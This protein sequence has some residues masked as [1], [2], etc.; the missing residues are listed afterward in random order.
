MITGTGA[1][2]GVKTASFTIGKAANP[3][4]IKTVGKTTCRQ[5]SLESAKKITIKVLRKQGKVTY[6]LSKAAK[7]A[8]IK[9]TSKGKVTI[10]KNCPK[11]KY[12]I[13]VNAAGNNN[14]QAGRKVVTVK[15]K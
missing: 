1:Y 4:K 11:G 14:Y 6:K 13:T 15:V 8:K 12:K 7:K 2:Q 9:V 3:L 5:K 10:P